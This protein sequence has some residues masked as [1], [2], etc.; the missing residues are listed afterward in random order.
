MIVFD[1]WQFITVPWVYGKDRGNENVKDIENV[2]NPKNR[3][4]SQCEAPIENMKT[5]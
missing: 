3:K 2:V 4:C 5:K 1:I